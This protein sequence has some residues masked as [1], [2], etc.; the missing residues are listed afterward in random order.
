MENFYKYGP[1]INNKEIAFIKKYCKSNSIE[2]EYNPNRKNDM[3]GLLGGSTIK[4][5]S[6]RTYQNKY[7]TFSN[8]YEIDIE[9]DVRKSSFGLDCPQYVMEKYVGRNTRRL[10]KYYRYTLED[11]VMDELKYFGMD[12]S[13]MVISKIKYIYV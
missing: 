8:V 2:V 13:D 1:A 7:H 10:N 6:I 12:R 5:K 3:Y 11:I 9:I 4:V